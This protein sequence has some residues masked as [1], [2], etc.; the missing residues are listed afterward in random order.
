MRD[1]S[2][3]AQQVLGIP[4][5]NAR[6]AQYK[7]SAH[8]CNEIERA[9]NGSQSRVP[10]EEGVDQDADTATDLIPDPPM[11][12]VYDKSLVSER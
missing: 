6:D 3:A 12:R 9:M 8:Q 11:E 5:G 1:V 2:K 10:V 4:P 7:L